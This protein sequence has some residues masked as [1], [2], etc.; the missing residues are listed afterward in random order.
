[1]T[2]LMFDPDLIAE[3]VA[4]L[5]RP[6]VD[7][8]PTALE[9]AEHGD[10]ARAILYQ[11]DAGL[12]VPLHNRSDDF[13]ATKALQAVNSA[14]ARSFPTSIRASAIDWCSRLSGVERMRIWPR[15]RSRSLH[16]RAGAAVR[17][18]PHP[19]MLSSP[20]GE[21]MRQTNAA[22]APGHSRLELQDRNGQVSPRRWRM[23]PAAGRARTLVEPRR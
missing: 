5:H 22:S 2:A 12:L 20:A 6:G 13:A 9:L 7:L 11:A 4:L 1:V 14:P 19:A 17:A 21:T 23:R 16:Q 3:L 10:R 8:E 15:T 18:K